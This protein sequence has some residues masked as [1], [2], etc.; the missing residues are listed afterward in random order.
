MSQDKE[1]QQSFFQQFIVFFL[2]ITIAQLGFS[3]FGLEQYFFG[4]SDPVVLTD[5][6]NPPVTAI[7]PE[8]K[9]RVI[10][11]PQ[12]HLAIEEETGQ[13]HEIS[14]KN[15]WTSMSHESSISTLFRDKV[16]NEEREQAITDGFLVLN[17]Q[18]QVYE[19]ALCLK[20]SI[21]QET[22]KVIVSKDFESFSA[23]I[24]Y[25]FTDSYVIDKAIT[26]SAK[27]PVEIY[28]YT[29][30]RNKNEALVKGTEQGFRM[31][32]GASFHTEKTKYSKI[33]FSQYGKK[34]FR[35]DAVSEGWVAFS[36]RYFATAISSSSPATL[37]SNYISGQNIRVAGFVS[38]ALKVAAGQNV[39]L[40]SK[41]YSGPEDRKLLSAFAP[42]LEY[43]IDFGIFWPICDVL[44]SCLVFF[45]K[46]IG[47]WGLSIIALTLCIRA[48]SFA[49]GLPQ[50][51]TLKKMQALQPKQEAL[52]KRYEG[53]DMAYNK[54]VWELHK[55]ENINYLGVIFATIINPLL[56]IPIF[57]GFYS[58]LMESITLRQ[59]TFLNVTGDLSL[60]DPTYI[61]PILLLLSSL[62]QQRVSPPIQNPD[63]ALA[64]KMMPFF[65]AFLS[66]TFPSGLLVY[67]IASN[68]MSA[69]QVL[70]TA[71]KVHE[72]S[73]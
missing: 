60:S 58:L 73:A 35:E 39:T 3:Y 72:R 14:L 29:E 41:I 20:T 25:T 15:Y 4:H 13:L 40:L 68:T 36:Q 46:F 63:M 66:T 26:I 33:P 5:E 30:L 34:S 42:D 67:W 32:Q 24:I 44:L 51:K 56:Q 10:T 31:F 53:D 38:P 28:S 65:F 55:Q 45:Q 59:T 57:I 48:I 49:I 23:Q 22:Q 1:N 69:V 9:T 11:T 61:L 54:A 50:Q 18:S 21:T 8:V 70:I 7:V 71:P 52:K 19:K 2:M 43:V 47:D 64:I 16:G 17:E 12:L 37:Y 6:E 62:L 27:K